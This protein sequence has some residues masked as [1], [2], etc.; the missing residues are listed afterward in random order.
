M[1]Y[2]QVRKKVFY[3]TVLYIKELSFYQRV[4]S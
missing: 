1:I 4:L 3:G 2:Q